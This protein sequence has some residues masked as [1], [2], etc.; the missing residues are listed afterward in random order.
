MKIEKF[1]KRSPIVPILICSRNFEAALI[2]AIGDGGFSISEGLILA[3]LFFEER[4]CRPS[5]I[6]KSLR[7][8]RSQMSQTLR[9][10]ENHEWIRRELSHES[11]RSINLFLTAKGKKVALKSIAAFEHLNQKVEKQLGDTSFEFLNK[12]LGKLLPL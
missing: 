3:T 9:R 10:L 5:E 12:A 7:I 1:V 8:S 6:A 2:A 4:A 11:A